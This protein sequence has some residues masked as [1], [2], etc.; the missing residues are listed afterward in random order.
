MADFHESATAKSK[1]TEGTADAQPP[2]AEFPHGQRIA[3]TLAVSLDASDTL[4][5]VSSTTSDGSQEPT[6]N[7]VPLRPSLAAAKF[8]TEAP[9]PV[10]KEPKTQELRRL[11][12]S[13]RGIGHGI[14]LGYISSSD[15]SDWSSEDEAPLS[16]HRKNSALTKFRLNQ[17]TQGQRRRQ[18]DAQTDLEPEDAAKGTK[19]E[20]C[21]R[22]RGRAKDGRLCI[23]INET[24]HSGYLAKTL[25]AT[26]RAHLHP[27]KAI[28]ER[29][30]HQMK[31][32]L[33]LGSTTSIPSLNIVI[34]VIGSRGDIQ[35]FLKIGKILKE[36]YNHRVRIATHPTFKKF[37]EDD[38]G[39]D[40]FSVG[41][42]P[43]ELMAFMVKN[44]GL[45]PSLDTIK[46]G[47]IGKRRES[48]YQMFQGFWR[49]C[50]NATDDETDSGNIKMM[51]SKFPF[52]ADAIIANPPSFAHYHCA[53][54]LGI[55]LHMV[56][57]FP[58]TPTEAFPHPLANIKADNGNQG[59]TNFMSYPL[60]DLMT[61]QG[62]GDLVN[63]FRTKTLGLDPINVLWAPGQFSRL[64]VP[65]TYLFSPGLVPKPDDWGSHVDIAGFVFLDLASSFKP[66][67]ELSSFLEKKDDR[68]LI[69]IG[70]G[71]ISGIRDPTAFTKMIFDAVEL[72]NVRAVVSRGW[73]GMGD[74]FDVPE[75]VHLVDNVPHDWL[76]PKMDCVVHHGGAGT[77]AIGLKCG[78][79]TM[80]VP[81]FG[82]QPFWCAM[83]V[84][85][86]A[87]AKQSLPLKK[88]NA[89]K[90]AEGIRQCLRPE[91]K[92]KAQEIAKSIAEEGDGAENAVDCF[93]NWLPLDD[94]Y[95]NQ[96]DAKSS[97]RGPK[98]RSMRCNIFSDRVAVW[99]VKHTHMRL[100][101]LAA[102]LLAQNKHLQWKDLELAR[103][104]DWNDF[105]G[106]GEPITGITGAAVESLKEALH[107][108]KNMR[109]TTE[110]DYQRYERAKRRE[111]H[112]TVA[113]AIVIPG[114]IAHAMKGG[115]TVE[116]G[117]TEYG[118]VRN[119]VNLQGSADPSKFLHKDEDLGTT[120]KPIRTT[121]HE[122]SNAI[123][124]DIGGGL[125]HSLRT[126]A[127]MP[128]NMSYSL[129]LGLRNAPR[130]Y[131]DQTVRR[132][133]S[134]ITGLS[135]GLS[136]AG[137]E[138]VMGLYDGVTGVVKNP[139][140]A[141]KEA[142]MAG[143][144]KGLAQ[145]L[146]GL[147]LKP[148][149]GT[150]GLTTYTEQGIR[151]EVRK[152]T[153]DTKR[154][155]RFLWRARM[156]QGAKDVRQYTAHANG[157][158]A[159]DTGSAEKDS[160]EQARSQ[161][162]TQWE[163]WSSDLERRNNGARK[164]LRLSKTDPGQVPAPKP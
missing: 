90:F 72:A 120:L 76:F 131:G 108:I 45:I 57:T 5:V 55:P 49:A 161:A 66:D 43:S 132:P 87:G 128:V 150:L 102:E 147:V 14:T 95:H 8:Q 100:S 80:I 50:I 151:M 3:S 149:A 4:K 24:A 119:Q 122:A 38:I 56:F 104:R 29:A 140:M 121:P 141:V 114:Q 62:L 70:F 35:P 61:W 73:G 42:D 103:P 12:T 23:S 139:Y 11:S 21:R 58:Y 75:S 109:A 143:L 30:G 48:M 148:T 163:T 17:A 40:F 1:V 27:H 53:E 105:R 44:P 117:K 146:G 84:K 160:I 153:R 86:G 107:D 136:A 79:P 162:L 118:K 26:L 31:Q 159:A 83:I 63:R 47:E 13:G 144:P 154:I 77:T 92:E 93:H 81:F 65:I 67:H 41:G 82:D 94:L 135:S 126:M 156:E 101:A 129:T 37:V 96:G 116:D 19:R 32:R 71:S 2:P 10:T 130:L 152:R 124:R 16:K 68:Q 15:S 111:K 46:A 20:P 164:F 106:P 145:G 34:M 74:G 138:F 54:R 155:E 125:G 112:K 88:L 89:E 25:G 28:E 158:Q 99:H 97:K 6:K 60:V 142:G 51:S 36:K 113:E 91:A 78:K 98:L 123:L 9:R 134:H 110:K 33:E 18:H 7:Q 59:H 127:L 157:T 52:V 69:Y 22:N 39:L 137:M 133:P 85:A 64:K 115:R